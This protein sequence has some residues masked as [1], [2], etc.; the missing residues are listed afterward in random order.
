M[1]LGYQKQAAFLKQVEGKEEDEA[2]YTYGTGFHDESE[3]D[4][5]DE[6]C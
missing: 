3:E 1:Q 5:E 2:E 6:E 4:S